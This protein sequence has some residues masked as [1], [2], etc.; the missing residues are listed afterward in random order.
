MAQAGSRETL[1][2]DVLIVG[3]GPAGLSAAIRLKQRHPDLAV[4]VVEKSAEIGG[5]IISGAVMDPVGLDALIPD[6]RLKGAP[7]GPAVT[8]DSFHFLTAGGD[9]AIPHGLVPP[10][11]KTPGAVIVSLGRLVQWLGDQAAE[12]G[13]DIFPMTAAVDVLGGEGAAVRGVITGDLGRDAKGEPKPGFAE[14]IA[15]EAK[16]TLIAEGARGSLAK[17]IIAD[18]ALANDPQKYGLGIKEV[19]EIPAALHQ[20]GRVDHY[21]GFPLDNATAGGGFA[22]HAEDRKLYLGL[23]TYLDYA[24]PTLSPFDE[25]QRFKTHKSIAPLLEGATRLSYGARVVTAGGWQSIPTLAFAGGGLIGC[26]AGFMNA[27]RLKAIHNAILSGIG[28]AD[29]VGEAIAAGRQHDV[30]DD[31]AHRIMQTG[32]ERE[33][34]G[35]RNAKPLWSRLG[36]IAGSLAIGI[37]LWTSAI[38][39]RSLLGT[40]HHR[41]PDHVGLK[42]RDQVQGR[43]YERPDGTTRFD[44]ASSVFLANL[45]HDEDQPVHLRLAD[46][47][48]PVRDNLPV[49]GEPAPLYCPAG[50]YELAEEGG[51]PIFRIHAANCVHCKTCDIKDPAQNIT[52]VPPEGGS[53]P[54]YSGM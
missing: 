2:T 20:P 17:H 21:L 47:A 33:L 53:G 27:P 48:V 24:D 14:G 9:F 39:G 52:W 54:N 11:M 18:N 51:A 8:R 1:S 25:F 22:Y 6:W 5:H 15:L 3:A 29:A 10:Q 50:V 26:S 46:P 4:T 37:D 36:T 28:A 31:F 35:V 38:F 19:W 43:V 42:R 45:S 49:Y 7:V 23:V 34:K 16:Y 40:L 32:I 13:V 30:I 41:K 44:R 12:L